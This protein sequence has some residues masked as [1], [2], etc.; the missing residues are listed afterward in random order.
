MNER[1]LVLV[2]PSGVK[3]KLVG[4]IISR[5]EK[6]GFHIKAMKMVASNE[7]IVNEH[8]R[9][10]EEW[11]QD[12]FNKSRANAEKSGK[13]FPHTNPLEFA[14]M[15]QE[16]NKDVLRAGPIVAMVVEG[17]HAIEIIRKI[18]GATNPKTA[19]PGTIRGDF[20]F[21][22]YDLADKEGRAVDTLVHASDSVKEAEREINLWFDKAE[23]HG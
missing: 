5:F 6:V 7:E 18:V 10:S 3:R 9:L 14:K 8:Y 16:R 19:S 22:S 12:V 4:E 11:A 23:I 2:K 17:P 13:E 1:S 21:D 15:I 20:L